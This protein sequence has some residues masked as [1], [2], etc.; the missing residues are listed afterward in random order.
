MKNKQK[1]FDYLQNYEYISN[2]LARET[3]SISAESAKKLLSR[4]VKKE[5]LIANGEN[6]RRT[7]QKNPE[8]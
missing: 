1:I 8:K 2:K 5:L 7:Y 6:K 3:L 4:M